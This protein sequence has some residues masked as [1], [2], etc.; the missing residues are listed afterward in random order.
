MQSKIGE[1]DS[2]QSGNES[3]YLMDDDSEIYATQEAPN[4]NGHSVHRWRVGHRLYIVC[5]QFLIITFARLK[6]ALAHKDWDA[7]SRF[8][9]Q[10]AALYDASTSSLRFCADIPAGCYETEVVTHMETYAKGKMSGQNMPD[11]RALNVV[12]R[13]L[14]LTTVDEH[15]P[16]FLK[17]SHAQFALAYASALTNHIYVYKQSTTRSKSLRG[18]QIELTIGA[19]NAKRLA[20]IG[21]H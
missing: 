18:R 17:L 1:N 2:I 7:A 16:N 20:T 3:S 9:Q 15:W 19:I 5:D 14:E 12:I 11:N 21:C 6:I 4:T 10:A 8:F 13:E